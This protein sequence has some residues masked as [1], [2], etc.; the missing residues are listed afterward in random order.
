L[1][2]LFCFLG[3]SYQIWNAEECLFNTKLSLTGFLSWHRASV[4]G[5]KTYC[6]GAIGSCAQ[7]VALRI[8]DGLDIHSRT[9]QTQA[10]QVRLVSDSSGFPT[11]KYSICVYASGNF[12]KICV[13]I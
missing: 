11:F 7:N 13:I 3:N 8:P 4:A 2:L 6:V 9:Q 10:A 1:F 5:N 12:P